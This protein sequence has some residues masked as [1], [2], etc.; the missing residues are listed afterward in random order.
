MSL[1][2]VSHG[3]RAGQQGG[4]GSWRQLSSEGWHLTPGAQCCPG[5][6][7][8]SRREIPLHSSLGFLMAWQLGFK[9]ASPDEQAE[10]MSPFMS[11]TQKSYRVTLP[12]PHTQPNTLEG[13]LGATSLSQE[14]CLMQERTGL[15]VAILESIICPVLLSL[16]CLIAYI[17]KT[18]S[19]DDQ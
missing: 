2:H 11:Q 8:A 4:L 14:A 18:T 12:Y 3:D 16:S 19:K 5:A 10:V 1:L 17:F 9:R 15:S 7:L 6:Q 13:T